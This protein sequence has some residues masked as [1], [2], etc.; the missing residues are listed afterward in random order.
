MSRRPALPTVPPPLRPYRL[1]VRNSGETVEVDPAHLPRE[2]G[3]PG[4]LLAVLLAAGVPIDHACGGVGACGTCHVR[5]DD[6]EAG[7]NPV[8]D[9][10]AD[11]LDFV[12]GVRHGS[13][14]ACLCVPDGSRDLEVEIPV[15]NRNRV[16]E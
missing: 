4:S 1:T 6:P 16:R 8:E 14:L 5:L 11:A 13:R 3:L 9:L 15:W 2:D 12:P 10:E 7:A